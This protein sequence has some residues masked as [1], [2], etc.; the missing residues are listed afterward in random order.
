MNQEELIQFIKKK[1]SEG[2]YSCFHIRVLQLCLDSIESSLDRDNIYEK[3]QVLLENA[4]SRQS[5]YEYC[6]V[7]SLCDY[8]ESVYHEI[9]DIT[10]EKSKNARLDKIADLRV[11]TFLKVAGVISSI[12]AL[13]DDTL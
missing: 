10:K 4:Q 8:I 12:Y 6:I 3:S 9:H 1:I 5:T 11:Q 2:G 7:R 13:K